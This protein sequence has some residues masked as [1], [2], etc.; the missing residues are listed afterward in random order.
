MEINQENYQDLVWEGSGQI[1]NSE[2]ITSKTNRN[3]QR[4]QN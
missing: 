4:Y 2:I 3:E 1:R